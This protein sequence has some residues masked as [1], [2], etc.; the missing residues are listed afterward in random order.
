MLVFL[1]TSRCPQGSNDPRSGM[2]A[3]PCFVIY[4]SC[5]VINFMCDKRYSEKEA[6]CENE[7]KFTEIGG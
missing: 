5:I 3:V 6:S 7:I 1:S 4:F 2:C